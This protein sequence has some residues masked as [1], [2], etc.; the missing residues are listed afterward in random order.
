MNIILYQE[1]YTTNSNNT[2]FLGEWK[3]LY[4]R[5]W[6]ICDVIFPGLEVQTKTQDWERNEDVL[7]PSEVHAGCG[8]QGKSDRDT[9]SFVLILLIAIGKK[10][11]T[12]KD[13]WS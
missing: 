8:R 2:S 5:L 3:F 4:Q 13:S 7:K 11:N 12:N 10:V 6:G 9:Y 1:I